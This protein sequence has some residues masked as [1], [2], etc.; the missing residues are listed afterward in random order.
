MK[1][2]L[3]QIAV[4]LASYNGIDWIEKQLIS[5]FLQQDVNLDLI[6]SD[7][8]SNDGTKEW[9]IRNQVQY[10]YKL[11][12]DHHSGNAAANFFR[13]LRDIDLE[14]YDYI[15]LS[16]QDDIW[17]PDKLSR[18]THLLESGEY[19]AYSSNVTAF[20]ADGRQK[21]IDKAQPQT[22]YDY[23]FE[24]AGPGCTFIISR[25]LALELQIFLRTHQE[26]LQQLA[27]HDWFVYAFARSRNYRWFIDNYVS[28]QYRQHSHNAFGVNSGFKALFARLLKMKNGWYSQ[29]I[30]LI[31]QLLGI[32]HLPPIMMLKRLSLLDRLKLIS[33]CSNYRRKLSDRFA[34][35]VFIL[36]FARKQ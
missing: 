35:A 28:M 16:D 20:W 25:K 33:Q 19:F 32:S 30:L 17:C 26:K 36:F 2:E 12:P 24:S 1:K 3:P 11:L 18:A 5:I 4:L 29:Q 13:L 14:F 15:A 21:I 9:L 27:L 6:I 34:L 23:L 8:F 10:P 22:R 31:A 7:D